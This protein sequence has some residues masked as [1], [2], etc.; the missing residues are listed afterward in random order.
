MRLIHDDS[1][2]QSG[3]AP[4]YAFVRALFN[5]MLPDCRHRQT[6]NTS[7]SVR[8][9]LLGNYTP[10]GTLLTTSIAVHDCS[11]AALAIARRNLTPC[12]TSWVRV[13]VSALTVTFI[14]WM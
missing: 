6:M 11:A 4:L 8:R 7:K 3:L 14:F 2:A 1:G 10:G 13:Y 12:N 5:K 9:A